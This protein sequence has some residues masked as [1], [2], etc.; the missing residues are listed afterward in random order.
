[1]GLPAGVTVKISLP[2]RGVN[3]AA[4]SALFPGGSNSLALKVQRL[5][6]I[7]FLSP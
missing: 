7:G 5:Q 3:A 6:E 4:R 2:G 1:L